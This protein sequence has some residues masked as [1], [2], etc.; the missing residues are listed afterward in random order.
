MNACIV[1]LLKKTASRLK[2]MLILWKWTYFHKN[3][4]QIRKSHSSDT[5]C[6]PKVGKTI[7]SLKRTGLREGKICWSWEKL[8]ASWLLTL[9]SKH[10]WGGLPLSEIPSA[11]AHNKSIFK[12]K[13]PRN[14]L[15]NY[16]W[17]QDHSCLVILNKSM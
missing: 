12:T 10:V 15:Y 8:V 4:I 5:N 9:N 16:E 13:E 14:Y 17:L 11:K 1:Q 2:S 3:S 7:Q 6:S